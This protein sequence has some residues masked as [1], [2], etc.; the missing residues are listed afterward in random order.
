MLGF[1]IPFMPEQA[2]SVAGEVDR[3]YFFLIAV[4]LFFKTLIF[5]M[6]TFFVIRY[7]RSKHPTASQE[8]TNLPLEIT[9]TLIPFILAMVIFAWGGKLYFDIFRVPA[10]AGDMEIFVVG[11]QWMWKFQHPEGPRE[12]NTLHVPA[13]R[14]IKLTMTSEDVIHS[15]YVPA[16]RI[17]HDVLP[18]RYVQI[19]VEPTKVGEYHLFCAEY[20]GTDHSRMIGRVIVMDP[21]DYERWLASS[22]TERS[23]T[24][25]GELLYQQLGCAACHS[26]EAQTRAP[27]LAGRFGNR[28]QLRDGGSTIFNEEY[29]RE[30]ILD[31]NSR[32]ADGFEANL[33]PSYRGTITEEG[34]LQ[35]IAYLKAT[36][37]QTSTRPE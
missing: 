1:D 24:A 27:L 8:H 21:S 29:I 18:G 33:M 14:P 25:S 23:M 35:I 2:S 7:R 17:K 11:K 15:L 16:F 9:W 5:V 32:I 12:I 36:S 28:V 26:P 10:A 31:P 19:W 3:L 13:G 34:I 6:V 37:G 22:Q 20:C 30:S 4:T